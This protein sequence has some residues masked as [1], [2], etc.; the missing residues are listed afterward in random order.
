MKLL[1][2]V[3]SVLLLTV[4]TSVNFLLLIRQ[5]KDL[6]QSLLDRSDAA[7]VLAADHVDNLLWKTKVF[8]LYDLLIFDDVHSDV[9]VDETKDIQIQVFDGTLYFD[10][11]FFTHFVA[12][13]I[14]DD[15]NGTIQLIQLQI[16]INGH[17]LS[18]FDMV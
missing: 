5:D 13:G 17:G 1:V 6:I 12:A 15:G 11:V 8:F 3:T 10:D 14:L 7:W 18:G 2:S 16:M 4:F 9:V